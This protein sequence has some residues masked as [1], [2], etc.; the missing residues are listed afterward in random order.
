MRYLNQYCT[1]KDNIDVK[2]LI[3]IRHQTRHLDKSNKNVI[4]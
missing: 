1:Y 2:M 4:L 3:S